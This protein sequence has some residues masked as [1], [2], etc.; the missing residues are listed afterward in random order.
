MIAPA[1][2]TSPRR[3]RRTDRTSAR[4]CSP[5]R[6]VRS[7]YVSPYGDHTTGELSEHTTWGEHTT[8]HHITGQRRILPRPA[9]E[10]SLIRL[11]DTQGADG[12]GQVGHAACSPNRQ[13]SEPR[14]RE[15]A[16]VTAS[17]NTNAHPGAHRREA[18]IE[19][20][21]DASHVTGATS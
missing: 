5:A 8:G 18:R 3:T 15:S 19:H 13:V 1:R 2:Q 16:Y 11:V 14:R 20:N 21:I 9:A 7:T 17:P 6:L 10:V 4:P 12:L